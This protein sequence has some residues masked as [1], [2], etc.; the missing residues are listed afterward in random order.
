MFEVQRNFDRAGAIL[1]DE[2][3]AK[4]TSLNDESAN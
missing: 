2:G 3:A 4:I 1:R